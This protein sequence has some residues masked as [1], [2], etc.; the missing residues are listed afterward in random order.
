MKKTGNRNEH[1]EE[2]EEVYEAAIEHEP[3]YLDH[4][5]HKDHKDH[6][7]II[8]VNLP[9]VHV[10][11]VVTEWLLKADFKLPLDTTA[12]YRNTMPS[13]A[14]PINVSFPR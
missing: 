1:R 10:D 4:K 9:K 6:N 11:R 2:E 5:D 7:D 13:P 3:E 12:I 8:S 14:P